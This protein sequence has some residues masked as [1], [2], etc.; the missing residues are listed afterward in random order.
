MPAKQ[1]KIDSLDLDLQNP[2]I[3]PATDQRDAMQKI[4]TEQKAKLINLAESIAVRGFSPMDRCLVMRSD[5]SGKFIVL[6][7]NR[8]IL[9]AKLLKNPSLIH[10]FAMP[11]AFR[12]R[13]LKASHKFDA[14]NIEPVD[15]FEVTD[16]AEGNEW[17]RRRHTGEDGGRGIVNWSSVA[18]SRFAGRDPALQA[19]EFVLE[20][21]N[22]SEDQVERINT[23]KFLTT[24]DRLLSNPAVRAEIGVEID[25]G[26][27]LTQLPPDEAIKPLKKIVLDLA[28]KEINVN[29]VKTKDQQNG[30]IAKLK[31][32]DRADLS[33]KTGTLVAV[34]TITDKD[35]SAKHAPISKRPHVRRPSPRT[36]L[37][38]RAYKLNIPVPKIA[39][40]FEE[41][42][43]LQLTRH[44]Q[45]ISVLFRVFLEISVD[46]Y[47]V[48]VAKL[49]LTFTHRGHTSEKKLATKVNETVEHLV[50]NGAGVQKDFI[51]VTKGIVDPHHP[52]SIDT[53]HAYIHNRHYSPTENQLSTAWDNAQFFFEKIWP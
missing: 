42:K 38:P 45:A 46:E 41:L 21:G 51:G 27:L 26:K 16:R 44:P 8:R 39:G 3:T 24:L 19:F 35:F 37:I 14:K 22:L 43:S 32:A 6:E 18:G 1:L 50:N 10:T 25:K 2:R 20:H 52:F 40:I 36:T 11:E 48:S 33:K 49:P 4:I 5:R 53:L 7:G 23:A 28:E 31:L 15:C 29:D 17:I 13:L 12:K 47:L 9:S 30:Y 34:D